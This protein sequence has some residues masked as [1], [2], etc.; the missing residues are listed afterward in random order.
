MLRSTLFA[1]ALLAITA[2]DAPIRRCDCVVFPTSEA[3]RKASV[4]RDLEAADVVFVGTVDGGLVDTGN[5]LGR[6]LKVNQVWKG[7]PGPEAVLSLILRNAG[8]FCWYMPDSGQ[9]LV[10][11]S[12]DSSGWFTAYSC[13]STGPI[14]DRAEA[15]GFLK[16]L[17]QSTTLCGKKGPSLVAEQLPNAACSRRRLVQACGAASAEAGR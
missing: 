1:Y 16:E 9:H 13:G 4:R 5:S 6:R 8:S 12:K 10:F 7:S 2:G 17:C 11:A 14:A 3:D 15:S